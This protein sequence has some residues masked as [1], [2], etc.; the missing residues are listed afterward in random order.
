MAFLCDTLFIRLFVIIG[1]NLMLV[2]QISGV[3]AWPYV[4]NV[5][6]EGLPIDAIIWTTLIC[7]ANGI[8]AFRQLYYNDANVRFGGPYEDEAEA[9]W[10]DWFRRS[11]ITRADFKMIIQAADVGFNA[12]GLTDPAPL[13][14]RA[15]PRGILRAWCTVQQHYNFRRVFYSMRVGKCYDPLTTRFPG[16]QR[17]QHKLSPF[18]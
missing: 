14:P 11:G 7:I 8:P 10:R 6:L 9:T 1:V 3:P 15:T 16:S 13:L 5:E 17:Y 2:W 18:I 12:N 4:W